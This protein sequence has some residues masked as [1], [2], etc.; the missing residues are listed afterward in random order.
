MKKI[1]ILLVIAFVG[2]FTA[3]ANVITENHTITF[4]Q[5]DFNVSMVDDSTFLVTS[6]V[7]PLSFENANGAPGIPLVKVSIKIPSDYAY[8]G[9]SF[10]RH[11]NL[12]GSGISPV[13]NR[14]FIENE[15]AIEF[16]GDTIVRQ[17]QSSYADIHYQGEYF[18]GEE[19]Y[20]QFYIKP[21]AWNS[22]NRELYFCEE[23]SLIVS[24]T[25][26][27]KKVIQLPTIDTKTKKLVELLLPHKTN[28]NSS[29]SQT[30]NNYDY[31]ILTSSELFPAFKRLAEWKSAKG[32][33]CYIVA[34][35]KEIDNAKVD[36]L[37]LKYV[38][39]SL[40]DFYGCKSVL[41]GGDGNAVPVV[42]C[43]AAIKNNTE[44]NT[45][46]E[47][48]KIPADL[49][50]SCFEGSFDWNENRNSKLGEFE[51]YIV[52]TQSINIGRASVQTLEEANEFVSKVIE[53]ESHPDLYWCPEILQVAH[54]SQ[55][56]SLVFDR[57]IESRNYSKIFI[58]PYFNGV[59]NELFSKWPETNINNL[60]FTTENLKKQIERGYNFIDFNNS[61]YLS[62]I[63]FTDDGMTIITNSGQLNNFTIFDPSLSE[64]MLRNKANGV[65][66]F[67][68]LT[69]VPKT[70]NTLDCFAKTS[71]QGKFI[72]NFYKTLYSSER[73]AMSLGDIVRESR[74]E[75]VVSSDR[76]SKYDVS[77]W[78][79][80]SANLLGDPEMP[81][82]R[83][84]PKHL[85]D[86]N[87][88]IQ[89]GSVNVT[90]SE[91]VCVAYSTPEEYEYDNEIQLLSVKNKVFDSYSATCN[92]LN[93]SGVLSITKEGYVP[94]VIPIDNNTLII[95]DDVI[96]G[97]RSYTAPVIK[98]GRNL[99][100]LKPFGDVFVNPNRTLNLS[101]KDILIEDNVIVS[102]QA[103]I[104]LI[105]KD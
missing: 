81:V 46:E 33:N 61:S 63:F 54:T 44:I 72:A 51:D 92:L 38:I 5:D 31:A 4:N 48:N 94:I 10:S 30:Y 52:F 57:R 49:F 86:V 105:N 17:F 23:Y 3:F 26:A 87:V 75:S 82:F 91:T 60:P 45:I 18:V 62:Q 98:I 16:V 74:N 24:L 12:V 89:N 47:N 102:D 13:F 58:E 50:Y 11:E 70:N 21:F 42:Y 56:N 28:S 84:K 43:Y 97:N 15:G 35:D 14:L 9:C 7:Y 79:Q 29:D 93:K 59:V 76:D 83:V 32:V 2:A 100:S 65:L 99:S 19:K 6:D 95:Q 34:I 67:W 77:R 39:G 27:P 37:G 1:V 78:L 8:T 53:Y 25:S 71:A 80:F 55:S 41:L 90:C 66:G 20:I 36:S 88:S 73:D 103:R 96:S 22:S 85:E 64:A 40:M 68:G 101:A 69:V 104:N